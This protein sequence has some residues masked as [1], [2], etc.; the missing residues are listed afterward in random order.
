MAK[1]DSPSLGTTPPPT[2]KKKSRQEEP[3]TDDSGDEC[4]VIELQG[5]QCKRCREMIV[6]MDYLEYEWPMTVCENCT[7]LDWANRLKK[8]EPGVSDVYKEESLKCKE[9]DCAI[10]KIDHPEDWPQEMCFECK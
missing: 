5:T 3:C 4:D 2:P 9:C 10:R 7:I 8:G 6:R 1:R